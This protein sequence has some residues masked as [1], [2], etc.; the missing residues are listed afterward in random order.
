MYSSS[1]RHTGGRSPIRC[2]QHAPSSR[3]SR[4]RCE[5]LGSPSSLPKRPLE[6]ASGE[7]SPARSSA[8]PGVCEV[9]PVYWP[10]D[11]HEGRRPPLAR[12]RRLRIRCRDPSKRSAVRHERY[13]DYGGSTP[14]DLV[15]W[16]PSLSPGSP[17]MPRVPG[18]LALQLYTDV[19]LRSQCRSVTR[20]ADRRVFRRRCA[21]GGRLHPSPSRRPRA[22]IEPHRRPQGR[23][24]GHRLQA[25]PG[26][27]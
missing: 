14:Q 3:R 13:S 12:F 24:A 1:I 20:C 22:A 4:L 18:A 11:S 10:H 7:A 19:V 17:V 21:N 26:A 15:A 25:V 23:F 6:T 5:D 8:L 16:N 27:R 2:N 9:A